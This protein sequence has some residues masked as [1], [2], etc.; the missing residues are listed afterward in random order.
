MQG[1]ALPLKYCLA[2]SQL[3][4]PPMH[5]YMY[6]HGIVRAKITELET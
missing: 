2:I 1:S 6:T 3:E 5:P 4:I